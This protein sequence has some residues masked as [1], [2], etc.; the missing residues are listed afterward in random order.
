VEF[1]AAKIGQLESGAQA[2]QLIAEAVYLARDL[3]NRPSNILTPS[4]IAEAAQQM[5]A[6]VGLS[7]QILDEA[8]MREQQM[9][10]L[11]A[12]TQGAAEP[13]KFI[14]MEHKP[15]G[16]A[17]TGPVI[18]VGKGVTFDTGGYSIKTGDG[19]V[20]MKG[21]MGGAA[22]V[23]G[24]M[25]AVA[26]LELPLHV[27]GLVPTVENMIGPTAYKP[28]DVFT[29]KNGVSVE[30]ISTDAEGRLI[31]ADALCYGRSD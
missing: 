15:A 12:V 25:R 28:N 24:A 3:I 8:W 17:Q 6:E 11:L 14:I 19:M 16:T 5:S 26:Q 21:D 20:G 2:G 22:A 18:L 13:A 23:I 30:I 9:G 1:D 27:V 4:A 10:A 7:C 31:L 29:A